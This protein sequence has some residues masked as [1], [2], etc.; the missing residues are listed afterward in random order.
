MRRPLT[1]E[2]GEVI[3]PLTRAEGKR[4]RPIG[5]VTPGFTEAVERLRMRLTME[6]EPT[7]VTKAVARAPTVETTGTVTRPGAVKSAIARPGA[8]ERKGAV[9]KAPG[10][11]KAPAIVDG[12]RPVKPP[13][14]RKR[15]GAS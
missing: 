15:R 7:A 13:G 8:I 5:E 4:L 1:D 6:V 3:R 14:V 2:D 9:T 12:A 11:G 10:T